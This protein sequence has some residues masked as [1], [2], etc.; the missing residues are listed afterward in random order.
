MI[1]TINNKIRRGFSESAKTYDLFCGLHREI[2][3]K[4]Y[5][6][7]T[8]EHVPC[9]LLDVGCGTGYL[10]VRLKEHFPQS[11]I[12]GLDFSPGMLKVARPK[13]E[14]ISWVLADGNNLPFSDGRFDIL[15]S[16]LAY[17][18]AGDLS[19]AFTQA[20]R[21]LAPNG[22]LA[23]TLFGYNTCQ[24]L[25]QSL[26]EAK[27]KDLQ[28]TRLPDQSQ[29]REA[30]ISSGFKNPKVDSE[31]IKIEYDG[32]HELIA[33]LKSIGANHLPVL[34]PSDGPPKGYL[35]HKAFSRAASI[36]RKKFSYFKGVGAT[37]EVIRVY[38][39]K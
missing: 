21:V 3:D 19:G 26:D 4:L 11:K 38:A 23:C 14:G 13:H 15:I 9:A 29:V 35:G 5:L 27:A 30:L 31:F 28:F 36:Y 20:R 33:W 12:I 1:K 16:N 22:V 24:E 39:K 2:A 6:Q 8:K 32:M 25:F 18:W 17:Q 34:L 37:F 7:V 10:T